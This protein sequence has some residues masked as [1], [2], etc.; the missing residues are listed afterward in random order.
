MTEQERMLNALKKDPTL[1]RRRLAAEASVSEE[2]ARRFLERERN[3]QMKAKEKA[4]P[5]V[6]E[7]ILA[8][9]KPHEK[10]LIV[11][12]LKN[13]PVESKTFPWS[14]ESIKFAFFTDP[15]FG[16][17]KSSP[18]HWQ[19]TCD[20]IAREKCEFAIC[21]GDITEGMINRPGHVYE[22]NAIG[23]TAQV[24]MAVERFKMMPCEIYGMDGNHDLWSF[25]TVGF[26]PSATIAQLLPDQYHH[27]GMHEFDLQV[28]N[29]LIKVWHGEDGSTYALSYRLQKFVEA[30]SGGEKPH[31]LLAGHDHK[32]GFFPFRNVECFAGGTLQQQTMWMRNKKIAAMVGFWIIEAWQNDKGLERTRHM[33]VPYYE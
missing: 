8:S 22:L 24:N 9:L 13:Y 2:I 31:I 26:D 28:G 33:W 12:G 7:D 17:L 10:K 20:L 18:E 32:S 27:M 1:G 6:S 23:S 3:P 16:H 5:K 30:L 15:H 21:G 14:K 11:A 4:P 29:L 19:K 25:K